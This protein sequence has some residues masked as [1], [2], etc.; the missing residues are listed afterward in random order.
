M[1]VVV[2]VVNNDTGVKLSEN[3]LPPVRLCGLGVLHVFVC[4]L[5]MTDCEA[6]L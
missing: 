6:V 3:S 1:V 2:V 5:S 4:M